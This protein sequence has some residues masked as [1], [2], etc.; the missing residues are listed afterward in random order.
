MV[1]TCWWSREGT[2]VSSAECYVRDNKER[3]VLMRFLL[4]TL[5]FCC[6]HILNSVPRSNGLQFIYRYS[7]GII[8]KR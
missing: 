1:I 8:F 6:D 5:G 7:H 2:F 4:F 3:I